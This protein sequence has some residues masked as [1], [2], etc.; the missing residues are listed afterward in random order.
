MLQLPI[1]IMKSLGHSENILLNMNNVG[2][3]EEPSWGRA[4][5]SLTVYAARTC[6]H[7]KTPLLFHTWSNF[8]QSK[9]PPDFAKLT[10][11]CVQ[12]GAVGNWALAAIFLIATGN[13][14]L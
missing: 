9:T 5:P 14:K 11:I 2:R 12:V 3:E 13:L 1:Q 7:E 6:P 8:P 4:S 10:K